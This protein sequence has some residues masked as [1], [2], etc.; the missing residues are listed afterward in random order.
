LR[1]ILEAQPEEDEETNQLEQKNYATV[2][3]CCLSVTNPFRNKIIQMVTVN[4]CFDRIILFVIMLNC[5]VLATDNEVSF[6]TDNIKII[7]NIFLIIYTIEMVLKIIAMGFCMREHSYLRDPWNKLDFVVVVMGWVSALIDSGDI[8]AI[9]V[10][11]ILRPLRTINQIPNMSSLV[12]TIF[13]SL[14]IMFEVM[15]LFA[16]MLIMFGTIATQLL[17]G[18]LDKRCM[19]YDP[20]IGEVTAALGDEQAE[21]MC[22]R[23]PQ[24]DEAKIAY[25]IVDYEVR[26]EVYENPMQNTYAFDNILL[27]ILNIFQIITLEGWT[28]MMYLVRESESTALYD[29]FFVSCVVFGS[30]VILN[31]MIAVQASYLDKAF[32]EEEA[33][34]LAIEE[35]KK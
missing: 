35:K 11:R 33:R 18:H 20:V 1:K 19:A 6:V 2:A 34:Q 16:F 9:R 21:V 28:D 8:S 5:L 15:I 25:G 30:F 26:C 17:G 13:N 24:C 27:S 7:D 4:P 32:D 14:P 23:Q 22:T 10:M 31:L 12:A 29:L 3:L